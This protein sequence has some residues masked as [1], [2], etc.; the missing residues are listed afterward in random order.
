MYSTPTQYIDALKKEDIEWPVRY[1]D[2][3]PYADSP[4]EYWTG[5]F[6]SRADKK[7]E[8]RIAQANLHASNK[9]FAEKVIIQ[10]TD[11]ATITS[12]LQ[13]NHGMFDA[14]GIMQHHD[15]ITGTAKQAV[16]DNYSKHIQTAMSTS[17]NLLS[18]F[19]G[20]RAIAE[21]GLPQDGW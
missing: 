5:Y 2:M 13:A 12:I 18:E 17:N 20:A 9:I 10:D 6:S 15:A 7:E 3:F 19:I 1:D 8:D 4:D 11:D 16:A 21:A 14:M